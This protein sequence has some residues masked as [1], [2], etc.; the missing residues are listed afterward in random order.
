[1]ENNL[2]PY[3]SPSLRA[4]NNGPSKVKRA[5]VKSIAF[6][7]AGFAIPSVY[8][9]AIAGISALI[10]DA[11]EPFLEILLDDLS[12]VLLPCIGVSALFFV[13]AIRNYVVSEPIGIVRSLMFV[14][15]FAIS[16]VLI[17][18]T[19]DIVLQLN[20]QT[21]FSDPKAWLTFAAAITPVLAYLVVVGR[22]EL[23]SVDST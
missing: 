3:K 15:G 21:Y 1:M 11:R 13:S 5:V 10:S 16:G 12:S 7:L 9:L 14:G 22:K 8:I 20:D 18:F 17:A 19:F 23:A 4:P 6:A 2:N